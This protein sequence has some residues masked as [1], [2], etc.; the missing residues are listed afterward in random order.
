MRARVAP[1]AA[2]LSASKLLAAIL[3]AV[4]LI[5]CPS[6]RS[7]T[8]LPLGRAPI[9]QAAETGPPNWNSLLIL[10]PGDVLDPAVNP[11]TYVHP[12][13]VRWPSASPDGADSRILSIATGLDWRDS[14]DVFGFEPAGTDGTWRARG[15]GRLRDKGYFYD[16]RFP[17]HD[18]P[19]APLEGVTG[20]VQKS[21][22]AITLGRT[23]P[24][25]QALPIHSRWPAGVTMVLGARDGEDVRAAAS[26]TRGR[27]L[28][29][30]YPPKA[31]Q[32]WSR[33]W[34]LNPSAWPGAVRMGDSM[35][36]SKY[37]FR[38]QLIQAAPFEMGM[39]IPGAVRAES[40]L[41]LLLF[42]EG[43]GWKH[44]PENWPGA[45]RWAEYV[46][47]SSLPFCIFLALLMTTL[48]VIGSYWASQEKPSIPLSS[49]L[50]G[51]LLVPA[52]V[53]VG[54]N[55]ALSAGLN[56]VWV[57]ICVAMIGLSAL[58]VILAQVFRKAAAVE[59]LFPFALVGFVA[60]MNANPTYSLF[61]NP[62]GVGEMGSEWARSGVYLGAILALFTVLASAVA[63]FGTWGR[64]VVVLVGLAGLSLTTL[65]YDDWSLMWL[66]CPVVVLRPAIATYLLPI[67]LLPGIGRLLSNGIAFL[68]LGL[69]HSGKEVGA[70]NLFA[71]LQFLLSP[72][73]L[74]TLFIG[75][76]IALFS[77]KFFA[78]QIR[79][80]FQQRPV[81]GRLLRV[82][83]FLLAGG[84]LCPP[85]LE[86]AL[87]CALAAG[88]ALLE[89][90]V[91]P[92]SAL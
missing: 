61:S 72:E 10:V 14:L 55:V 36:S 4:W 9:T 5:V 69:I 77:S 91:R 53:T 27:V 16:R 28:I 65:G 71:W 1:V 30:E 18:T 56:G 84:F 3:V 15:F 60:M 29:V 57:W 8:R 48:A 12:T 59:P 41:P 19:F 62:F 46:Q 92:A 80:A 35:P 44:P 52:A 33:I 39:K 31:N 70:V 64:I 66:L 67:A 73:L 34:L 43:F 49:L 6:V 85:M 40:L 22:L 81:V 86:G 38:Y 63:E 7:Q 79:F 54:G 78:H 32:N 68:P 11:D 87:I 45:N 23:S 25:V 89:S 17:E 88:I 83:G 13:W 20:F 47:Q 21:A 50:K 42:P 58:S 76:T 75:G 2:K 26:E 24:L 82:S 37:H 90:L 51:M 74:V